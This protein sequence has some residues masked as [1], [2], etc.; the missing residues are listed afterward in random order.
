M[1][2]YDLITG[3]KGYRSKSDPTN[4]DEGFL[5]QGSQNVLINDTQSNDDGAVGGK[6]VT[7]GGMELFAQAN[8]ANYPALSEFVWKNHN[9]DERFLKQENGVLKYYDDD[10]GEF[11]ELL[12][13]L[14]T[15][16][17]IRYSTYWNNTAVI[18]VLV[19]V[20]HSGLVYEWS[21][22]RGTL[23]SVAAGTITINELADS[24]EG[25]FAAG[26]IRIK[27]TG[28]T[29]RA[30]VYTSVAGA[31]FT[32][33]TDLT[34]YTFATNAPVIQVVRS[35][36]PTL[37]ATYGQLTY[38]VIKTL[39][40]QILLGSES[41]RL[42][43]ISAN[44]DNS[45]ALPL[46]SFSSPRLPGQGALTT[47]DDVV[48]ALEIDDN[49][50]QVIVFSGKN[51][52][53]RG[54]F[55]VS[56]G[57]TADREN[58]TIKPLLVAEGQGAISQELVGK[59]KQSIVWVSNNKE[60]VELGQVENLPSP[61]ARP[62]SDAIQPDFDSATFTNG[63]VK[64]WRNY[65]M[66]TAP[67]DGKVW[68][69][70][71]EDRFWN[72]PQIMGVRLLSIYNDLLYGHSNAVNETYKLFTGVN[73]NNNPISFKAH[74]AYRNAGLRANLKNFDK[75]FTELYIQSNTKVQVS[76]LYEWGGAKGI[77]TWELDGADQTFQFTPSASA[78]LGVNS[79]G[80]NPLGGQL[81]EGE[82]TPKH[83]R[84]K[85]LALKDYFEYGFRLESE[86]DDAVF[87]LLSHGANVSVSDSKPSLITK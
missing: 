77:Q 35:S 7:R 61:Q 76:I 29:W 80:T 26:S 84:F 2:K 83:R 62:I 12:T 49:Q 41:S 70:D 28:G 55:E 38:D 40:N 19:F 54:F 5:I 9:G 59:I 56:P 79:L 10:S 86:V 75:Y 32:V 3:C 20:N 6:V 17:P 13:G 34:S 72:P 50:K 82:S 47:A 57:S 25:F 23:L 42:I 81:E 58:F 8:D 71:V 85:K 87:Q 18:D 45:G 74:F 64:F 48:I 51:Q 73:D 46:F 4:T 78:A 53:Y 44:A 22:A 63:Q 33:T 52:V 14:S 60:L 37:Q 30:A 36:A 43:Y 65:L 16:Y 67:T 11:E 24:E 21:G 39:Q 1:E 66:V 68:I 31:A 27:D 15:T 69:Y